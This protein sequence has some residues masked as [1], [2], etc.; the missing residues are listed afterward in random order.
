MQKKTELLQM[1]TSPDFLEM[2]DE[3]RRRVPDIPS[4]A[5]AIRRLVQRGILFDALYEQLQILVSDGLMPEQGFLTI[6]DRIG[7]DSRLDMDAPEDAP[8]PRPATGT[9]DKSPSQV[10]REHNAKIA[11]LEGSYAHGSHQGQQPVRDIGN[12]EPKLP[13]SGLKRHVRGLTK[14]P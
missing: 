6:M 9:G 11:S 12:D 4:R 13:R 5:E 14:K 8:A 3:W 2:L 7:Y 1:R 10:W